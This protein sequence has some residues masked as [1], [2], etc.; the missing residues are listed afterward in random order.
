MAASSR[1]HLEVARLLLD[2]GADA[3]GDDGH[4]WNSLRPAAEAGHD[5]VARE[6]IARGASSE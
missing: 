2:A 5:A 6:L 3:N 4:G 1:G